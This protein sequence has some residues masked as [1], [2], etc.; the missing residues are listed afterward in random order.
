MSDLWKGFRQIQPEEGEVFCIA[1]GSN[2]DEARMKKRCPTAEVFGTSVIGG[3]RLL[4]KRS[5]TGAYATIEQDANGCVPVLIYRM[6]MDDELK[7]DWYEGYPKYYYKRDFL[8][9]VWGL[10]GRKRKLRRNCIAYI[11]HEYRQLGEPDEA[12]FDLLDRGYER[13]GFDKAILQKAL[14]DSIGR[15]PANL[16]LAEY[17]E[18]E[19]DHE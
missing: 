18:E 19:E 12:Y 1:Y 15:E 5:L 17:Y 13:W 11:L 2:L 7:L 4:F 9:P 10:N 16:W 14:E 6:Q 3:Y 8:L